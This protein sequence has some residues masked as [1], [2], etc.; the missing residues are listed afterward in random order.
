[1]ADG[2]LLVVESI[3]EKGGSLIA[4]ENPILAILHEPGVWRLV[5]PKIC[6][7]LEVSEGYLAESLREHQQEKA[8]KLISLEY[9]SSC[10]SCIC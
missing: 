7:E 10:E 3:Q 1:M 2:L 9:Q 4:S 5:L 6:H 8:V